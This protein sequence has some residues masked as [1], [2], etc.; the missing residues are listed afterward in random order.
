MGNRYRIHATVR[1][2]Y[3]AEEDVSFE[4]V[5]DDLEKARE[6]G[7]RDAP[8]HADNVGK[9]DADHD[10]TDSYVQSIEILEGLDK[11]VGIPRCEK[12]PD[13]FPEI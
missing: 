5:A 1:K 12:T 7:G 10:D 13:M 6:L 3:V 8:K 4:I 11:E 2:T 9:F